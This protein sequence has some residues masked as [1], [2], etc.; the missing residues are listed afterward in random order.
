MWLEKVTAAVAVL[1]TAT[2]LIIVYR[3]AQHLVVTRPE[4][5]LRN[6]LPSNLPPPKAA[7]S[8][9]GIVA[10]ADDLR[11]TSDAT[12]TRGVSGFSGRLRR[13]FN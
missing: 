11:G 2:P 4:G 3:K 9:S 8:S 6:D 13:L 10:E 1:L 7:V 12:R 5:V